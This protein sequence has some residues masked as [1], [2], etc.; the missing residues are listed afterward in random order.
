MISALDCH[1]YCSE[2]T[3]ER[4]VIVTEKRLHI[5]IILPLSGIDRVHSNV[6][7]RKQIIETARYML[8][9]KDTFRKCKNNTIYF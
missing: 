7:G 1:E 8:H 4:D 9:V 3:V 5:A 2:H 6:T